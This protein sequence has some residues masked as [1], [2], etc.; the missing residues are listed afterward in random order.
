MKNNANSAAPATSSPDKK[1][2]MYPP[3]D[4][5]YSKEDA[6]KAIQMYSFRYDSWENL[7]IEDFE[8]SNS[9]H[10]CKNLADGSTKWLDLRKKPIRGVPANSALTTA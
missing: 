9:M 2:D 6:S 5:S 8:P 4:L 3:A 1:K 7:I 10:K